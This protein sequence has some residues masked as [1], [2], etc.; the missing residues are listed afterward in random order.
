MFSLLPRVP[1]F[2]YYKEPK[3]FIILKTLNLYNYQTVYFTCMQCTWYTSSVAIV[4][5]TTIA[6]CTARVAIVTATHHVH[7]T[8]V[9]YYP[10]LQPLWEAWCGL[11][12]SY[13]SWPWTTP[14]PLKENSLLGKTKE[15][16]ASF[17]QLYHIWHLFIKVKR[18]SFCFKREL[19]TYRS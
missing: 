17:P 1:A 18:I 3:L 4:T 12:C 14:H 19:L 5:T 16:T 7:S 15:P 8:C 11:L 9:D 13:D 6:L 10:V 2:H